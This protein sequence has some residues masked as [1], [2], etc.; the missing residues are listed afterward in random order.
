MHIGNIG[1]PLPGEIDPADCE[2]PVCGQ[3]GC[4]DVEILQMPSRAT[5]FSGGGK[6]R[7]RYCGATAPLS[8]IE[9]DETGEPLQRDPLDIP[10]PRAALRPNGKWFG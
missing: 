3:C 7:C 5:W 6:V 1:D 9:L 10:D 2:M 4:A 8:L